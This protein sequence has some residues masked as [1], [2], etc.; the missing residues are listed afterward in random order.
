MWAQELQSHIFITSM[1][2]ESLRVG[3][4]DHVRENI[5]MEPAVIQIDTKKGCIP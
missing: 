5:W 2:P 4:N 3:G 1:K